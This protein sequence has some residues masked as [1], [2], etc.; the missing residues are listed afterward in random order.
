MEERF[1]RNVVSF[2]CLVFISTGLIFAQ[3]SKKDF[4][5]GN[6]GQYGL[7][8]FSRP[9]KNDSIKVTIFVEIPFSSLQFIKRN[10]DFIATYSASVILKDSKEKQIFKKVW[11]DSIVVAEY[12]YT[13]S[14]LRTKKHYINYNV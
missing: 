7:V 3:R 9:I 11:S 14:R 10:S 1:L 8:S 5:M 6:I 12:I 2:I 13:Q 4:N